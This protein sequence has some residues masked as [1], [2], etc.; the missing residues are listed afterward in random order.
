LPSNWEWKKVSEIANT[1][2]GGTPLR[3]HPE[4][5]NGDIPWIKSGEL[6]DG[7]IRNAEESITELGMDNSSTKIFPKGSVLVALYGATAGKVGIL[8][9]VAA[10][11]Q[12]VCGI[13]PK[14]GSFIPKYMFYW[15]IS[16]RDNLLKQRIGGAQPNISQTIIRSQYFPLAPINIQE[17]IVSKI[18][19]LFSQLDAGVAGLKRAQAELQRYRASVLKAA[20]E[21]R[22][23]PQDPNDEPA[24]K[25]LKLIDKNP[26][27]ISKGKK[28]PESWVWANLNDIS[29]IILGQSPPSSSYNS[30]GIGL[31]F[32][33]GKA[34]FGEIFPT[35][36]KWCSKPKKI[37]EKG[38]V[39]IS[40][41]APVGPTNLS[42]EKCCIGRGLAAI[43]GKEIV[44]NRYILYYLRSIEKDWD[45]R[46]TGTTF[47]AITGSVLRN[48]LIPLPP[49]EEQS[50]ILEKIESILSLIDNLA[51][52]LDKEIDRSDGLR[53]SILKTAFNGRLLNQHKLQ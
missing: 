29:T 20:F 21:G 6:K 39:L 13:F 17:L 23:V 8:D 16:Q 51:M 4:Y 38:D 37:A 26:K 34:E 44:L 42:K 10:T 3:S 27:I 28:I 14:N 50:R 41:R 22:L 25:L 33:Q 1:K 18:E 31:P 5:F 36:K 43:R 30:D 47:K 24:S 49:L 2:S 52:I 35:V 12:A 45:R 40:V 15:I 48:N 19:E 46:S 32:F 7:Y 53:N 9:I 11:N